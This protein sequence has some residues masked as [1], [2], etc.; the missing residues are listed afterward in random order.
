MEARNKRDFA[1]NQIHSLSEYIVLFY[2]T[3]WPNMPFWGFMISPSM[4]RFKKSAQLKHK[5]IS[6][7]L[8]LSRFKTLSCFSFSGIITGNDAAIPVGTLQLSENTE[9]HW[10]HQGE[11]KNKKIFWIRKK[12]ILLWLLQGNSLHWLK[13]NSRCK[14]DSTNQPASRRTFNHI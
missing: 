12:K 1:I 6:T 7:F 11:K 5:D 9:E 4:T 2:F 13:S 14:Q 8:K 3:K 10:L